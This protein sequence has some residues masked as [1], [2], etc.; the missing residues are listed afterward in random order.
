MT[1]SIPAIET[2]GLTKRFGRQTAVSGADIIVP[3]ACVCGFLGPIGA[4]KTTTMKLVLG[5]LR[6]DQGRVRVGGIDLA[7]DCRGA[8]KRV[9]AVVE[10]PPIYTHLTGPRNLLITR[11]QIGAP[12]SAVDAA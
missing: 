10:T 1:P 9:G 6:P 3:R 8:L 7:R 2:E 5:L 12:K 4:G 11:D